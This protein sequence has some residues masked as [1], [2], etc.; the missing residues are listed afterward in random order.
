MWRDPFDKNP[1]NMFQF[2]TPSLKVIKVAL[3]MNSAP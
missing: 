2:Q 3:A 1:T